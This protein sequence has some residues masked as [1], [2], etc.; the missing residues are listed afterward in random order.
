MDWW[1]GTRSPLSRNTGGGEMGL[2][3]GESRPGPDN[4]QQRSRNERKRGVCETEVAAQGSR[5]C[6]GTTQR[7]FPHT[8]HFPS[9]QNISR[10]LKRGVGDGGGGAL[11]G[12]NISEISLKGE[13]SQS[14]WAK[15]AKL[16]WTER[17]VRARKTK[18]STHTITHTQEV[19]EACQFVLK[20]NTQKQKKT[21][22]PSKNQLA[23]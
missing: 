18:R 3:G 11:L 9:L 4:D 16:C 20:A 22:F 12:A 14:Y 19:M 21:Q 7:P 8:L 6:R 5:M 10:G 15:G 2:S 13:T 1:E 17:T 23:R